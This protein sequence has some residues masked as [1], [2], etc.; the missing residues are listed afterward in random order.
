M[1]HVSA[2]WGCFKTHVKGI[3][4]RKESENVEQEDITVTFWHLSHLREI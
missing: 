4:N 3:M 2:M 1:K